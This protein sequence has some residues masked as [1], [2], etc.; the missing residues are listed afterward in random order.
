[1]LQHSLTFNFIFE[2]S[3]RSRVCSV[4]FHCVCSSHLLVVSLHALRSEQLEAG[5]GRADVEY[6]YNAKHMQERAE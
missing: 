5:L 1:M 2:F 4:C 3:G 6:I